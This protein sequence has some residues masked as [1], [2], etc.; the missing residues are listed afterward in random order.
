LEL[1]SLKEAMLKL[2]TETKFIIAERYKFHQ[3]VQK[4]SINEYI[5]ELRKQVEHC[6]YGAMKDEVLRDKFIF[7]LKEN[8]IIEKLLSENHK[9][10][11]IDKAIQ[12][13]SAYDNLHQTEL[14]KKDSPSSFENVAAIRGFKSQQQAT[15]N[16]GQFKRQARFTN[17][18]QSR[19]GQ[20]AGGGVQC[21]CCGRNNHT[22]ISCYFK[23]HKCSICNVVGHT[24][25]MCKRK[26]INNVES[27]ED[28][29]FFVCN[30]EQCNDF[31][32][33][34]NI[35]EIPIDM[36]IDTGSSRT[37]INKASAI[38]CNAVIEPSS[39]TLLDYGGNEVK[40]E[41]QIRARFQFNDYFDNNQPVIV[42]N[43]GKNILGRD[44]LSKLS[45]N[46][47]LQI[48]DQFKAHLQL[49]KNSQPIF[50]RPRSIPLSLKS[51]V[52]NELNR[53]V[54]NK[55]IVPVAQSSWASPLVTVR[56]P[57]GSLRLCGDYKRTINPNL[58]DSVC[59]IPNVDEIFSM[60]KDANYFS[61]LDLKDAYLQ[62][63]IDD[64][65]KDLTTISTPFGLFKYNTLPFGIK[66]SPAIFQTVINNV[67]AGINNCVAYMDDILI[68]SKSKEDHGTILHKVTHRL[69]EYGFE[70]NNSK[71]EYFK[72]S[73]V[74]LGYKISFN[75]IAPSG[76]NV[77]AISDLKTPSN[78]KELQT[79]LGMINYYGR[80]VPNIAKKLFPLTQLLKKGNKW[81]WSKD[82]EAAFKN[83]QKILQSEPVLAPY[84]V[85]KEVSLICD[86]S[87]IAIGAT[88]E[89]DGH[90]VIYI[91]KKLSEAE[92]NYAQ[93]DR[94]AL[95]IVWAIEKLRNYLYGRRFTLVTDHK[96]LTFIFDDKKEIN[97]IQS[98]R[99]QRWALKLTEFD[100]KIKYLKTDQIPQSDCLSRLNNSKCAEI[101]SI[102]SVKFN[103]VELVLLMKQQPY[104]EI[105]E[106]I[107]YGTSKEKACEY[108]K[109][110]KHPLSEFSL[111]EDNFILFR[112]RVFIPKE[113]R[114]DVLEELHDSHQGVD[115]CK[116]LA[117]EIVWWPTI[118]SDIEAYVSN[119]EMCLQFK[120]NYGKSHLTPWP[121]AT[122]RMERVHIDICGP[123]LNKFLLVIV[124]AY[125]R[126][127]EVYVLS[128]VN[129]E[130]VKYCLRRFFSQQ[131]VPNI[132]VSDNATYFVSE[133]LQKWFASIGTEHL[134][135]APYHPESNGLAERFVGTLKQHLK[136]MN[137]NDIQATVDRF[138]LQYRTS[139][140]AATK[141]S[142]SQLMFGENNRSPLKNIVGKHVYFRR[143]DEAFK[144]GVIEQEVGK[145]MVTVR[146]A[147]DQTHKVHLD[148][149]KVL[150]P[151]VDEI[152]IPLRRSKRKRF[153]VQRY[154]DAQRGRC[155]ISAS[156]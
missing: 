129:S 20:G 37:I 5:S 117:R 98:A 144:P 152:P 67:L 71:S 102:E 79:L 44:I 106:A 81:E 126:W 60:L 96:P 154:T 87:S 90:P 55:T 63:P 62:V 24:E 113:L 68:Y 92:K 72:N 38:K 85:T 10:L 28:E 69:K 83:I 21:W 75:S 103:R 118:N 136:I 127:P 89:Q 26:S 30:K 58:V 40:I 141:Q 122:H 7:G 139:T 36:L 42:V 146:D 95:A 73:I 156:N 48:N 4:Q 59:N 29:V 33:T 149:A 9:D 1:D 108:E 101:F 66:N 97:K 150:V 61:K 43:E 76:K 78:V 57:N 31:M 114:S 137:N 13:A 112:D 142:P 121:D 23:N 32:R 148:Q 143:K 105:V 15:A 151:E 99:L 49:K 56:K 120:R 8:A 110:L 100:F 64:H 45:S 51:D 25:K 91:S 147:N 155:V 134:T 2:Y 140:H 115:R 54:E 132:I 153:P 124:D 123:H 19:G 133:S 107:R 94:E 18:Y 145:A 14:L 135:I 50:C 12:M 70:I 138:L 119:C 34:V 53:L 47:V 41:G 35:N 11:T 74:Y 130:S 125:T 128:K 93:I 17:Q 6:E 104:K 16:G 109:K 111:S 131:G 88:L 3:I 82:H 39:Q 46:F 86:A 65:S 52:K 84:D 80:F 27:D 22:K 116:S 77:S